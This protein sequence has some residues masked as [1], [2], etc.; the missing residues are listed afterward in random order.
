MVYVLSLVIVAFTLL[1]IALVVLYIRLLLRYQNAKEIAEKSTGVEDLEE[2]QKKAKAMI[3]EARVKAGE[4]ITQAE[5]FT[6]NQK[7]VLLEEI[8]KA[9]HTY[10]DK[11]QAAL[12]FAEDEAVR[13][14]SS[15]PHQVKSEVMVRI[16]K[17][18]SG[19]DTELLNAQ[20]SI[21]AAVKETYQKAEVE[22]ENY[23]LER[24]KQVDESIMKMVEEVSRRVL[25]KEITADEHEKLVLKALEKAK[26]ENVLVRQEKPAEK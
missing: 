2:T 14:I 10:A 23:K 9:T 18:T 12:K 24:L 1:T 11:Y 4:V 19:V 16:E 15:I 22:V 6:A 17:F 3:E 13:M 20:K 25:A 5:L 21:Q 8:N 7:N 26:E